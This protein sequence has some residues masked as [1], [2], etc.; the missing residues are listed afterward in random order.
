MNKILV[1]DIDNTICEEKKGREYPDLLPRDNVVNT[2][3]QYVNDGYYIILH[4]S[5][6]M[7]TYQGNNGKIIKNTVPV[8]TEWLDKWNIYYDELIIGKPWCG[9]Q[10]FYVDDRAIRPSEFVKYTEAE[11]MKILEAE[12]L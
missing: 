11:I 7:R 2:L 1:L 3:R 6:Q 10:G 12:K 9:R 8:L 4:T 5:R